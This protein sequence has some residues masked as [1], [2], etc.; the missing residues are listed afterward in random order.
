MLLNKDNSVKCDKRFKMYKKP[1]LSVTES[2]DE[3]LS[4]ITNLQESVN[5]Y[6]NESKF[7][8]SSS[9]MHQWFPEFE[10]WLDRN[11]RFKRYEA[12]LKTFIDFVKK[13][14]KNAYNMLLKTA[15]MYDINVRNLDNA[16][17]TMAQKGAIDPKI[18]DW[19]PL[20]IR[21]STDEKFERI[22]LEKSSSGAGEEGTDELV[23]KLKKD[24]PTGNTIK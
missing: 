24:T 14:P 8:T 5:A 11:V 13:T 1:C 22:V 2:K 16:F 20:L 10:R 19:E 21:E 7:S 15:Q 18:L 12:A 3:M 23:K 9:L 6:M 4:E 17:R